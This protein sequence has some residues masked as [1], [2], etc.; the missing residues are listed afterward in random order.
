M[1]LLIRGGQLIVP[2]KQTMPGKQPIYKSQR[3]I[4]CGLIK[5][6][7]GLVRYIIGLSC[8]LESCLWNSGDVC[9][10]GGVILSKVQGD[11]GG[12]N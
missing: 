6:D 10:G 4:C 7:D 3:I 5:M 8:Q 1:Q 2:T 12:F 9:M 11:S